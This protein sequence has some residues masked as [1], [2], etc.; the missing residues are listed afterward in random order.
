MV[1]H[2]HGQ[3]HVQHGLDGQDRLRGAEQ[4]QRLSH[5]IS[6][7]LFG[8]DLLSGNASSSSFWIDRRVDGKVGPA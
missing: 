6:V 3:P 8:G 4:S 5:W 7:G 2:G 1:P